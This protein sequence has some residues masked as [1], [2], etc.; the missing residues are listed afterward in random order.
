M[1]WL[2][3][4]SIQGCLVYF[5]F[6]TIFLLFELGRHTNLSY[7]NNVNLDQTPLSAVSDQGLHGK[8][9]VYETLGINISKYE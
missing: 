2:S 7:V 6:K 3:A 5:I 8:C 4:L 1:N 9:Q